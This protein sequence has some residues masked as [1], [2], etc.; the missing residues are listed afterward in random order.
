M[1]NE[2]IMKLLH[3]FEQKVVDA[4]QYDAK[5][6]YTTDYISSLQMKTS[7]KKFNDITVARANLYAAIEKLS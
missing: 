7:D 6:E 5:L 2:E 4:W 3:I 1:V